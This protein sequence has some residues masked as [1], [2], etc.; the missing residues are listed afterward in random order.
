MN[1][2]PTYLWDDGW[3][4]GMHPCSTAC[5]AMML[6]GGMCA[7][8]MHGCRTHAMSANGMSNIIHTMHMHHLTMHVVQSMGECSAASVVEWK[9]G[10]KWILLHFATFHFCV[11]EEKMADGSCWLEWPVASTTLRQPGHDHGCDGW[12]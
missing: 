12:R 9:R 3:V 7:A 4:N 2:T 10:V 1:E 5:D 11:L 6:V 8:S